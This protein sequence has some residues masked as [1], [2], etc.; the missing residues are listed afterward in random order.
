MIFH[1]YSWEKRKISASAAGG[2]EAWKYGKRNYGATGKMEG[3]AG[4]ETV[5]DYRCKAMLKNLCDKGIRK[6]IF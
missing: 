1:N 4:Q 6:Q 5:A 2:R 3:F